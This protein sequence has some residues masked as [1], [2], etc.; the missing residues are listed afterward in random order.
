[1]SLRQTFAPSGPTVL[2]GTTAVQV[3]G[4]TS[5]PGCYRVRNLSSSVAYFTMGNSSSVTA[6][7]APSAGTPSPNTI[8]ML[9][10]SVETFGNPFGGVDVN[11]PVAAYFISA[12]A[13]AFEVT[14]GE[15]P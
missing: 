6:Q 3:P 5:V 7:A 15:G 14:P 8:G 11:S 2:V 4:T 12:N 13:A 9:P 1:M 10:N